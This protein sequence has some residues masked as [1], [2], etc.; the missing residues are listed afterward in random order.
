MSSAVSSRGLAGRSRPSASSARATL[1]AT[2][3]MESP[4]R[5]REPKQPQSM[6]VRP[7]RTLIAI[8]AAKTM[9]SA[10]ATHAPNPRVVG[11][12]SAAAVSASAMS[13]AP[14]AGTASVPGSSR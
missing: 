2:I 12:T 10:A 9:S 3:Q 8:A 7:R 6:L 4:S 5:S 13:S 1:R 11:Q 14:A